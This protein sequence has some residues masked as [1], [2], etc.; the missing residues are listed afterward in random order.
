MPTHG[1]IFLSITSKLTLYS[2]HSTFDT[3]FKSVLIGMAGSTAPRMEEI[4]G[5]GQPRPISES[6][7]SPPTVPSTI[8][9]VD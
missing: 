1:T 3:S 5:K 4:G 9:V 8:H 2:L 7:T 6:T